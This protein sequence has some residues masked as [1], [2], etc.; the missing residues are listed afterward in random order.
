MKIWFICA[1]LLLAAGCKNNPIEV[2]STSLDQE[3]TIGAGQR[4][5]IPNE[6]LLIQFQSVAED[7]RCPWNW[8]C[9]VE[10]NAKLL[11]MISKQGMPPFSGSIN[12][13]LEPK[14]L[15]YGSYE[16]RLR[17]LLPY[18]EGNSQIPPWVYTATLVVTKAK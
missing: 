14:I 17:K 8:S 16:V 1:L 18:P 3:F 13:L 4:A 2:K 11:L 12:T 7:S 9:F 6:S 5:S 10:G 15:T